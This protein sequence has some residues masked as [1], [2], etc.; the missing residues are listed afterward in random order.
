MTDVTIPGLD[1]L[2]AGYDVFGYYADSRSKRY[3]LFE[4]G[5]KEEVRLDAEHSF[6]VPTSVATER[7]EIPTK[8]EAEKRTTEGVNASSYYRRMNLDLQTSGS[9]LG[10]GASMKSQFGEIVSSSRYHAYSSVALVFAWYT[11]ELP[12]RDWRPYLREE[13]RSAIEEMEPFELFRWF[14]T[15]YLNIVEVG[16]KLDSHWT[17][18]LRLYSRRTSLRVAAEATFDLLVASGG[19]S[20]DYSSDKDARAFARSSESRRK[21]IGGDP[22]LAASARDFK[23]M[24]E[25]RESLWQKPTFIDFK[26][27]ESFR[28]VWELCEDA[29]PTV[30]WRDSTAR[31]CF[32]GH[33][34]LASGERAGGRRSQLLY[35]AFLDYANTRQ[36]KPFAETRPPEVITQIAIVGARDKDDVEFVKEPGWHTCCDER[37]NPVDLNEGA[38]GHYMYLQYKTEPMF[39]P[40]PPGMIINDVRIEVRDEEAR[41]DDE[42]P[43]PWVRDYYDL[44]QRARG[45]F[46]YLNYTDESPEDR[47]P[48]VALDVMTSDDDN[49]PHNMKEGYEPIAVNLNMEAGGKYVWLYKKHW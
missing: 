34:Y 3:H 16:G 31:L 5:D 36:E 13:A 26:G 14:G 40:D 46:L 9:F 32:L 6:L 38:G 12:Y 7:Q 18:D 22:V 25:W 10:F 33:R 1:F 11:L 4:F 42:P 44:N 21:A 8:L 20:V 45:K 37:G 30:G 23:Q 24:E 15:H 27:A 47:S 35:E 2:G 39:S 19:A 48:L 43:K 17:T 41:P 29:D 49:P 28:P